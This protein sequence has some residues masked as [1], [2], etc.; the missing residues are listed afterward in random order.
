[1]SETDLDY[2]DKKE[3]Y[4]RI[5]DC[6][7]MDIAEEGFARAQRILAGV[8]GGV[9]QAVGSALAR[10]GHA[11]QTYAKKAVQDE[12]NISQSTFLE[13]T[14]NLNHFHTKKN[15]NIY[16]I[17]FGFQGYTIP[18][19]H[20]AKTVGIGIPV[21]V[22]VLKAN[23]GSLLERAFFTSFG[24]HS[25]RIY[26]RVGV[27]RFPVKQL[28]GP[29]TTQMMYSNEAVGDKITEKV[30]E[31]FEKRIDHEITRVLNGWGVKGGAKG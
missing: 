31:T 15:G 10:A 29:A 8:H 26:E 19:I 21:Y 3:N 20:F 25:T 18:L 5:Y 22:R 4:I 30:T 1:M 11:G 13:Y 7:D 9:Y 6:I 16:S 14:R 27:E 12:Y 17:E 2:I 28:Y 24:G 23:T